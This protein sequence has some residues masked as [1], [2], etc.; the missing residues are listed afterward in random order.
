[1]IRVHRF[2]IATTVLGSLFMVSGM[3]T[4][5]HGGD[6]TTESNDFDG[7]MLVPSQQPYLNQAKEA[8]AKPNETQN[9]P[10]TEKTT[11]KTTEQ[12]AEKDA[13]PDDSASTPPAVEPKRELSP[14]LAALRDRVRRVLTAHHKPNYSTRQNSATEIMSVCRAFGCGAEVSLNGQRLNGITCL[15]WNY[16]CAGFEMLGLS[17]DHIAARI[18][19]GHQ[20]RPGEF[21]AMLAM[22]RVPSDY[23]VRVGEDT[24]TI[25]DLVEAEKLGCRSGDDLSLKLIS[26]MY[27]VNDEPQWKNDLG[28][29]WSI[30]RIIKEEIAKPVITAPVGG[31]NRLLGLSYVVD[32]RTKRK[33]PIDGQFLRAQKYTNDFHEFALRL[34]NSDGSW[35]PHFLAAKSTSSDI[36]SQLRSTGRVFEWLAMSLPEEKLDDAHAVNAVGCLVRLLGSQRYQRNTPSLST[37]EIVAVG[38]ALHALVVYDTRVF[39]PADVEEKP[40]AE[41]PSP[42][43][44]SR[45]KTNR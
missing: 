9:A 43:A 24:R 7:P 10:A 38:H 8:E 1:M 28:E 23:P 3:F 17:G 42:V 37:E 15:C 19:Y 30:E 22:A 29:T 44:A 16:P 45:Q 20:E 12:A 34:Q 40:A 33:Q 27:Y 21:L 35:G 26:L 36:K 4:I 14:E 5:A 31:L 2:L 11:P 25:A 18:G 39:K 41:K 6:F 32:R 13:P